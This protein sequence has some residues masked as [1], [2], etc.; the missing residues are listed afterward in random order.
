MALR[1]RIDV[2]MYLWTTCGCRRILD[3]SMRSTLDR[4]CCHF[5]LT[6]VCGLLAVLVGFAPRAA[7]QEFSD[8]SGG[9]LYQRFC[10][11]CH[12]AQGEGNGPVAAMLNVA[13]PDLT[14]LARRHRGGFPTEQVRRIVDGRDVPAAHGARRMPVWGYEFAEAAV[15]DPEAGA[16][17]AGKLIDRLIEFLRSIQ[18]RTSP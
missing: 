8:Y 9:E 6:A 3:P 14:L 16:E 10:A 2:G 18:V 15:S 5:R 11:S 17:R 13:V 7:A 1:Q 4:S 12:G